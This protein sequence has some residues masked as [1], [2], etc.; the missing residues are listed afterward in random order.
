MSVADFMEKRFES[1]N[2]SQLALQMLQKFEQLKLPN[3]GIQEKYQ[4]ILLHYV[5]DIE[6]V[7]RLYQKYKNN[8]PVTRDYPLFAGDIIYD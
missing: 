4:Q 8:P 2:S 5:K 6:M 3:L 1:H 7:T